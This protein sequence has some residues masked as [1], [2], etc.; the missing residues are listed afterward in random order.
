MLKEITFSLIFPWHYD[1][2]GI[3]A[4]TM[5]KNKISPYA[6]VPKPEIEKF[7]NQTE[8]EENTLLK[9]EQ[10]PSPSNISHTSTP[11]VQVEKRYIKEVSPSVTK[12]SAEDFQVYRKRTKTS[13]TPDRSREEDTHSTIVMEG[14]HSSLFSSSHHTMST[15]SSKKQTDTTLSTKSSQE[16][17]RLNIFEKYNLTKKKN[18]L[19]TNN[20]YAQFWKKTYTTQHRLLYAFDTE[21]G[22]MHLAFLQA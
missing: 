19:L 4:E 12:V 3:I 22:R 1:P 8:W 17:T 20:T 9:I 5:L 16:P 18:E 21:K 13:H 14:P 15:S 10:Q 6:H 7:M 2:R 11:Q